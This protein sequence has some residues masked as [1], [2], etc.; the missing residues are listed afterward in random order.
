MKKALFL[1]LILVVCA[2]CATIISGSRQDVFFNSTPAGATVFNNG[3]PM[4]VT[5][6]VASLPRKNV[7]PISIQLPGFQPFNFM[8]RKTFNGWYLGNL[9]FGGLIGLIVDPITGA[10]YNLT[11]DQVFVNFGLQ[12]AQTPSGPFVKDKDNGQIFVAVTLCK[13]DEWQQIGTLER[14]E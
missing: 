11:P 10:I 4:G 7:H 9:I 1:F 2:G 6:L 8:I 13:S 5:P 12:G 3:I 14:A